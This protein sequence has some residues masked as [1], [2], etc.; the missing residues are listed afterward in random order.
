M[1]SLPRL[2]KEDSLER[3]SSIL[4]A[5][6]H[7]Q[8][9]QAPMQLELLPEL[10]QTWESLPLSWQVQ[11]LPPSTAQERIALSIKSNENIHTHEK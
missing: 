5:A 10:L 9:L 2:N 1:I 7:L 3:S 6:R 11:S 4:E 8:T